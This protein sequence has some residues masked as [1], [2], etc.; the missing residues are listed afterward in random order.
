MNIF[1]RIFQKLRG[2]WK[3]APTLDGTT[4]IFSQFGT[5]IYL[6][7][8]V[9]QAI[10]CVV[11]EI[12]KTRPTHIRDVAGDPQPVADSTLQR[13][14]ENPNSLMT[15]SEFIEKT[16]WLLL[17]NKNAF[18]I[19]TYKEW[20]DEKTGV[21][22]RYYEGMVPVLPMEVTFIE[23][24]AKKLFIRFMFRDGWESTLA[25]DDVIHL[26]IDYAIN[27]YMGGD[28]YGLPDNRGILKT[29]QLYDELLQGIAKAM[30]ASY[31]I[32][33]FV[34]YNTIL[35]KENTDK[36]IAEF[37]QRL[38]NNE[39]GF[40]PLDVGADVR[41]FE[42]KNTVV[43]EATLKFIDEK[44]LRNWGV[45]LSILTGDFTKEQYE[46][47]SQKTLEGYLNILSQAFTKKL[48]TER[49]KAY[50]NKIVFYQADLIFMTVGQKLEMID[51]LSPTGTLFENEKRVALG[52]RPLPELEGKRYM[53][54]NWIEAQNAAQY[55]VGKVNVDVVDE[56]KE[57]V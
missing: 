1:S 55:Q 43:D 30:N 53:S 49:E 25:Y 5:D 13:V 38:K 9:Q 16:M 28:A 12:K 3:Y 52:L 18:I 54:L 15:Q 8:V 47:F 45:P 11:G 20:T 34:K 2:P 51:K 31:A 23:D 42:R 48:F 56:E 44:I 35:S 37:N 46:A 39:S 7:D 22:R 32:N 21:V 29:V 36:A 6:S 26:R 24:A 4:P 17:L 19:P 41:V 14:L 57:D 50:G 27:E 33:G 40:I 10:R